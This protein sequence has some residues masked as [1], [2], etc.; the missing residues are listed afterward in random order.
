[1][2]EPRKYL[3]PMAIEQPWA[4]LLIENETTPKLNKTIAVLLGVF[5][6]TPTTGE[7]FHNETNLVIR[8]RS[9]SYGEG[10]MALLHLTLRK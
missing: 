4:I 1:M 8:N 7:L 3:E 6:A 2:D 9:F 10:L 5:A